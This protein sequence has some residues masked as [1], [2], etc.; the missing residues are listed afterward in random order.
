M[1]DARSRRAQREIL[2]MLIFVAL[3]VR[4]RSSADELPRADPPVPT[5][6]VRERSGRLERADPHD[7]QG[8]TSAALAAEGPPYCWWAVDAELLPLL[9][10]P[11]ATSAKLL[12]HAERGGL[13]DAISLREQAGLSLPHATRWSGQ[14]KT[15][16][17]GRDLHRSAPPKLR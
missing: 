8:H 11:P 17:T 4:P 5:V 6:A 7:W 14:F 13:P 15:A 16:C 9:G 2:A 10:V 3:L 12:Q 1:S